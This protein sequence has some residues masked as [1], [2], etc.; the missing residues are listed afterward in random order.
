MKNFN[1]N[2]SKYEIETKNGL[3]PQD[4]IRCALVFEYINSLTDEE[5]EELPTQYIELLS[6]YIS[7]ASKKEQNKKERTYLNVN[8]QRILNEMQSGIIPNVDV[9]RKER[10]RN[11]SKQHSD[12][13]KR[14]T[15]EGK[16]DILE[17]MVVNAEYFKIM[18]EQ[19]VAYDELLKVTKSNRQKETIY[20]DKS[21][22]NNIGMVCN[23]VKSKVNVNKSD[24]MMDIINK[25]G[26][27]D[28]SDS[29]TIKELLRC[30]RDLKLSDIDSMAY[31]IYL[32]LDSALKKCKFTDSQVEVL[33]G[34]I[35][36]DKITNDHKTLDYAIKK[37]IKNLN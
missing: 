8:E 29:K 27:V 2:Y 10:S 24:K 28:Y 25:Y 6:D 7:F 31:S 20:Q 22:I 4:V 17:S 12:K 13:R 18:F 16:D 21:D 1:F 36:G 5:L 14:V 9:L 35:S 11:K 30:Y 34:F 33:N 19:L 3:V 37:I 15:F 26:D 32:D 23:L